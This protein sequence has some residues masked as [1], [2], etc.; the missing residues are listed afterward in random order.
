MARRLHVIQDAHPQTDP[1]SYPVQRDGR[2]GSTLVMRGTEETALDAMLAEVVQMI[3]AL[4]GETLDV[5]P[6]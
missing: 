6:G 1:G 2:D 4:G 3:T 5:Q